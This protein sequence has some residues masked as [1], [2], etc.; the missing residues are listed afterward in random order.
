M[1]RL[2][3]TYRL[4]GKLTEA[5]RIFEKVGLYKSSLGDDHPEMLSSMLRLAATYRLQ[6]KLTEAAR[7]GEELVAKNIMIGGYE[8]PWRLQNAGEID[9]RGE[10]TGETAKIFSDRAR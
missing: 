8:F 2:T 7:I 4:Q 5:A 3:E 10:G 9:G 6:G 1:I